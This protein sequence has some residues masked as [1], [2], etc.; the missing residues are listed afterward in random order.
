MIKRSAAPR[1]P[2]RP[3]A[4]QA[5]PDLREQ[6]LDAATALFADEGI[7]ATTMGKIAAQAGVTPAM[8][9]YYFTNRDQLL[10]AVVDE[11]VMRIVA[12]VWGGTV[13]QGEA[14]ALELVI[15]LVERL[16]DSAEHQPWLPPLWVREVLN[17]GGLLRER[18]LSRLPFDRL[19]W[20]AERVA[21]GQ[22]AGQINP[23][24]EPRLVFLS[25]LGL[26]LLPLATARTWQRVPPLAG[27]G[28][29]ALQR[30]VVALLMSGLA[31]R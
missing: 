17:E 25:V 8:V 18:M 24:I 5:H 2:G 30:H 4:D 7:A 31:A 22:R 20:L 27:L 10:D 1:S 26:T 29:D 3:A 23:A 12:Y 15:G 11:R 21:V 9:H 16:I 13:G 28:R 19:Q 14:D 6:L